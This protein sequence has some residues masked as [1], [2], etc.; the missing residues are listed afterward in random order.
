MSSS[1][2]QAPFNV[3]DVKCAKLTPISGGQAHLYAVTETQDESDT[4]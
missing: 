3:S 4:F 1:R 2:M